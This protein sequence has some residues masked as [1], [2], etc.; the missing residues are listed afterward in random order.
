MFLN[1]HQYVL[2]LIETHFSPC[3]V[4]PAKMSPEKGP[5]H[6]YGQEYNNLYNYYYRF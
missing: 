5:K 3:L 4:V 1:G 2:G 6:I